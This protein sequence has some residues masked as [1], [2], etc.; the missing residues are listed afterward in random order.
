MLI[1]Q[2][3]SYAVF[4]FEPLLKVYNQRD[5]TQ[6]VEDCLTTDQIHSPICQVG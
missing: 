3:E 6:R 5:Q 2:D 1:H 4:F